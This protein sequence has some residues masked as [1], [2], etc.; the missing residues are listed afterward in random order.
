MSGLISPKSNPDSNQPLMPRLPILKAEPFAISTMVLPCHSP[1]QGLLSVFL[2]LLIQ[3]V[4]TSLLLESYAKKPFTSSSTRRCHLTHLPHQMCC[5]PTA[6]R[7]M[8]FAPAQSVEPAAVVDPVAVVESTAVVESAA[9]A[10]SISYGPPQW[11][12]RSFTKG[13]G[14][15][16]FCAPT[17]WH[18]CVR[19]ADHPLTLQERRPERNG[20][21]R[22]VYGARACHCRPC[23]LR[24]QCQEATT[25]KKP[26]SGSVPLFG[27]PHPPHLLR[28][29]LHRQQAPLMLREPLPS[30]AESA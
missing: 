27:P 8:E 26:A 3:L 29:R 18:G 5:S 24:D 23:S 2:S 6:M 10:E 19:P 30:P 4:L 13:L 1:Q 12:H 11:A 14:F 22:M 25:T 7:L 9:V 16:R 17:R 15:L 21:V 28:P 20:S